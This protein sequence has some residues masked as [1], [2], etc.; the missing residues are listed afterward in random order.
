MDIVDSKFWH[1]GKWNNFIKPLL[2]DDCSEMTFMEIG[3][4]VGL[5]LEMAEDEGF[6]N[7]IGIEKDDFRTAVN[8]IADVVLLANVHY[9]FKMED[10]IW[11]IDSLRCRTS[12]LIIVSKELKDDR[13]WQKGHWIP[14]GMYD[15]IRT[16]FRDWEEVG[17]VRTK[18]HWM[19]GDP[20]AVELWSLCFKGKLRR[21]RVSKY[22]NQIWI[23]ELIKL[24]ERIANNE[25]IEISDIEYYSRL[26][27]KKNGDWSENKTKEF[28]AEKIE[29]MRSVM[30]DGL[31]EPIYVH[32]NNKVIDGGHRAV[33]LR[34]LGC[35][36][37]LVRK[38]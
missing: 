3:E 25:R 2:P 11:L 16:W 21:E 30:K 14:T 9:N 13:S 15:G 7:V 23:T 24:A 38:I 6:K 12:Y 36:T 8:R 27:E 33:M 35:K 4:D 5:Y 34:T 29:V 28:I 32:L 20:N 17:S 37:I 18:K 19:K 1:E 22:G 26:L 10:L 31:H